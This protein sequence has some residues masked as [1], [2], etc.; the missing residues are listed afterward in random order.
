M[1]PHWD[2]R[3]EPKGCRAS[4]CLGGAPLP[5]PTT[6]RHSRGYGTTWDKLRLRILQRDKWLCVQCSKTGRVSPATSVDHIKPKAKGGTDDPS[7][8]QSLC[9][10]CRKAKDARDSGRPLRPRIGA[11]GWPLA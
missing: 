7:N 3:P 11:D 5:W 8:L 1:V 2:R 9:G 4:C 6:S 10:E